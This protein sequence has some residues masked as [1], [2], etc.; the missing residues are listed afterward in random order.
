MLFLY[1]VL[2]GSANNHTVRISVMKTLR[3]FLIAKSEKNNQ[4]K[5]QKMGLLNS[6]YMLAFLCKMKC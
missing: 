2:S 5:M 6:W 3:S 1:Y 4:Q